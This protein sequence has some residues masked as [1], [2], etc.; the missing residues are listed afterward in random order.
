M[1]TENTAKQT[2]LLYQSQLLKIV[3]LGGNFQ[4]NLLKESAMLANGGK[5]KNWKSE[6]ALKQFFIKKG[7]DSGDEILKKLCILINDTNRKLQE[8]EK[9][10]KLKNSVD[11]DFF[12]DIV[13]EEDKVL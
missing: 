10:L 4:K 12:N 13:L 3:E 6:D 2:D 5:E 9:E 1:K 7:N 8:I 11:F